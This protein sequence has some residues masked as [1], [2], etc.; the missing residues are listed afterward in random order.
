MAIQHR[1]IKKKEA[2]LK[3]SLSS[4]HDCTLKSSVRAQTHKHTPPHK[5]KYPSSFIFARFR[6]NGNIII[7]KW[8]LSFLHSSAFYGQTFSFFIYRRGPQKDGEKKKEARAAIFC[9]QSFFSEIMIAITDSVCGVSAAKPPWPSCQKWRL[10]RERE[11]KR[12]GV[13]EWGWV[14]CLAILEWTFCLV[15]SH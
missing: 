11:R 6:L 3:W 2:L 5:W 13:R 1:K 10:K 4:L 8:R 7:L 15:F 9:R 14:L 12:L